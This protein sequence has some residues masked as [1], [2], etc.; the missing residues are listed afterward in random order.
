MNM[1]LKEKNNRKDRNQIR[2]R[3][4][5]NKLGKVLHRTQESRRIEFWVHCSEINHKL[6]IKC[7]NRWINHITRIVA[8]KMWTWNRKI[9]LI[10]KEAATLRMIYSK[11]I[12]KKKR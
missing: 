12:F 7:F 2:M 11:K 3:T 4:K 10:L 8:M 5:S 1:S 9:F 6:K